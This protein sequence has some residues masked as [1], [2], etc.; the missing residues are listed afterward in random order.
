MIHILEYLHTARVQCLRCLRREPTLITVWTPTKA[1]GRVGAWMS[2]VP[3]TND[4]SIVH[5]GDSKGDAATIDMCCKPQ[6]V[7]ASGD[8][9]SNTVSG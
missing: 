1:S 7:S 6:S 5:A 9:A 8:V 2:E 3:R 4:T